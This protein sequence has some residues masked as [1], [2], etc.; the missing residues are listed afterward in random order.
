[1][2]MKKII[3][4]FVKRGGLLPVVVQ[5]SAT[6]EILMLAYVNQEAYEK[7]LATGLATY[8]STSRNEIW[9]KG[10]TS[11]DFQKIQEIR[12]DCDEDS[13]IYKVEQKGRGACHTGERSCF[14]R[15]LFSF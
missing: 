3:P 5:D 10:T 6:S 11:G 7:T 13:L 15:K 4:D 1:M 14:F 2:S 9:I 12:I 8:Y